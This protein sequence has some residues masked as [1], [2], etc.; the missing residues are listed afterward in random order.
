MSSALKI[1]V[2]GSAGV[3]GAYFAKA[4]YDVF[5]AES[6]Y[7]SAVRTVETQRCTLAAT[8][9][10][11]DETQKTILAKQQARAQAVDALDAAERAVAEAM[12]HKE[13]KTESLLRAQMDLE[14][15]Q[16]QLSSYLAEK[17]AVEKRM[18]LVE[19]SVERGA[20]ELAEARHTT[21]PAYILA[22]A[23]SLTSR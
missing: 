18:A 21:Q 16:T 6:A 10:K 22:M 7:Q 4:Y 2:G 17:Q 20:A 3:V 14:N 12:A 5:T 15:A 8:V 9:A 13:S 11:I 1:V 23:K 19:R